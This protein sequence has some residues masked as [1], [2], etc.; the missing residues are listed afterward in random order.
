MA[1]PSQVRGGGMGWL[2]MREGPVRAPPPPH[3][4]A[5]WGWDRPKAGSVGAACVVRPFFLPFQ[6]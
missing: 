6:V 3:L 5:A 1:E 2:G 4:M